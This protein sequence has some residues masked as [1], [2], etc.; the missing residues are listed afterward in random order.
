MKKIFG[1][2]LAVLAGVS[3]TNP[4]H[5]GPAVFIAVGT[6]FGFAGTAALIVGALVV[7]GGLM[8]VSALINKG[9]GKD[10]GAAAGA[11]P[12][13]RVQTN[14]D[15]KYKIPVL[16]G[17]SFV[18]SAVTDAYISSDNKVMTYVFTIAESTNQ[19][20]RFSASTNGTI[21]TVLG[22]PSTADGYGTLHVGM[23]LTSDL[24][25]TA[26]VVEWVDGVYGGNGTWAVDT[27]L[28]VLA[29]QDWTGTFPVTVEDIYFNDQRLEFDGTETNKAIKGL[30]YVNTLPYTPDPANPGQYL[31][32]D[33]VDTNFNG[34]VNVWV[35][36]GNSTAANNI[37][38]G[39]V[40]AYTVIDNGERWKAPDFTSDDRNG[41]RASGLIFAVLK[42][43]YDSD[44]GFTS[45]PNMT[46][47]L[48]NSLDNPAVA[49]FDYMTSKRYGADQGADTIDADALGD[50]A[51]YCN[52]QVEYTPL[53]EEISSTQKRYV[54]NGIVDTGKKCMENIETMLFNAACW[55]TYDV[56]DGYWTVKPKRDDDPV[57]FFNDNN[58]VSGIDIS[59][60]RLEDLYNI[61]KVEYYDKLV[62]DQRQYLQLPINEE[63]RNYNEP[64][65]FLD[66]TYDMTNTNVQAE[67]LANIE[68]RQSRED[69]V[70]TFTAAH[71]ALQCQAGDVIQVENE[72]LGWTAPT[73]PGGKEFRVIELRETEDNSGL[74]MQVKA[75]EYNPQVYEDF[76][77]SEFT[78]IDNIGIIGRSSSSNIPQ[79]VVTIGDINNNT[80]IPNFSI[81]ATIP[82]GLNKGPFDELQIWYSEG[83]DYAGR[84]ADVNLKGRFEGANGLIVT[85]ISPLSYGSRLWAEP[86]IK[87]SI[88]QDFGATYEFKS[89]L[90]G[91]VTGSGATG[92]YGTSP[93]IFSTVLNLFATV[94]DGEFQGYIADDILYVIPASI[95]GNIQINSA[96]VPALDNDDDEIL[97]GTYIESDL[98]VS[99]S[100]QT[101]RLSKS[102]TVATPASPINIWTKKPYPAQDTYQ[103]LQSV[104]PT[105]KLANSDGILFDDVTELPTVITA[106]ITG[107]PA[108]NENKKY[109]I[110]ARLGING[111]YGPFSD[112]NEV[113]LEVPNIYWDPDAGARDIATALLKQ[114][115]GK[116]KIPL[117]GI[118]QH[119]SAQF[120]DQGKIK[121][122]PLPNRTETEW[123]R[124]GHIMDLGSF[125]IEEDPTTAQGLEDFQWQDPSLQE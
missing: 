11:D 55:L 104:K 4:A 62:K 85:F 75:L 121:D 117:N 108:N 65:N 78:T 32:E 33:D 26:K 39:A 101:Y 47:K 44:K 93:Q 6:F 7:I 14:P 110:K 87:S 82:Q 45:L 63:L 42:L 88:W 38:G 2:I 103:F 60:T 89:L 97:P 80:G 74:H 18:N 21:L 35:W 86:D 51:N 92:R 27:D 25:H 46:F 64:D 28:G 67:R 56:Y 114:D 22:G 50:F 113:D 100:Y 83:D 99:G 8:V 98:G 17:E 37:H 48:R 73:F 15:T 3:I 70:I 122:G 71:Y 23:T 102:Q 16:Y 12:G 24:G 72:L 77:I 61:G 1:L 119:R 81:T 49:F 19:K 29:A 118:W 58:I 68:V 124:P 95:S 106:V 107:L 123:T 109:F 94:N 59:A 90:T 91:Y 13:G 79:P 96:V 5:A 69:L 115:M 20:C 30:K 52:D 41:E 84:G 57:L 125:T 40:D 76:N 31:P 112:I 116:I 9:F 43:K 53:G 10:Q 36:A 34:F 120:L 105:A 54:C 66:L 111:V